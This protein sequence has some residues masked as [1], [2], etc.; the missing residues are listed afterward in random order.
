[1]IDGG[2]A[3]HV[4]M[5]VI[6]LLAST[7]EGSHMLG[8]GEA[9]AN[10]LIYSHNWTLIN[11]GDDVKQFFLMYQPP[12]DVALTMLAGKACAVP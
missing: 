12:G 8:P 1:M 7:A 3:L 6:Y 10:N 4:Q 11:S 2:L 9:F 5:Y